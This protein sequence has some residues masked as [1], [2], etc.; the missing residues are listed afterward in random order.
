MGRL[1]D[2]YDGR[3]IALSGFGQEDDLQRCRA[4][5]FAAHLTKP[6]NFHRLEAAIRDVASSIR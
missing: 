2:R 5:G 1:R 4:A 6:V 3:G